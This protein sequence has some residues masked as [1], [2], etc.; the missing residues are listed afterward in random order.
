M[1]AHSVPILVYYH[2]TKYYQYYRIIVLPLGCWIYIAV[3]KA[4]CVSEEAA[5]R[6]F[7][8]MYVREFG[9]GRPSHPTD[10]I[11]DVCVMRA[12]PAR[13]H[14][15]SIQMWYLASRML[16]VLDERLLQQQPHI[17][18]RAIKSV[19]VWFRQGVTEGHSSREILLPWMLLRLYLYVRLYVCVCVRRTFEFERTRFYGGG[20]MVCV[21]TSLNFEEITAVETSCV[22]C[23]G[24]FVFFLSYVY[25]R[26]Y[27]TYIY[28]WECI[29]C[30]LAGSRGRIKGSG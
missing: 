26:P 2:S 28:T 22:L 8:Y 15:S 19:P 20:G 14:G 13:D 3:V 12:V 1:M 29:L 11:H 25:C 21:R 18:C 7:D 10:I 30:M 16:Q 23:F 6:R 5:I 9:L 27:L 4:K 24:P 17:S